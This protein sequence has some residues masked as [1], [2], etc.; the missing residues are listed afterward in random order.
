MEHDG[1]GIVWSNW[2]KEEFS[3]RGFAWEKGTWTYLRAGI[4]TGSLVEK[5]ATLDE[6]K[7]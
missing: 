4:G 5:V 3:F 2:S 7:S 1:H 6:F